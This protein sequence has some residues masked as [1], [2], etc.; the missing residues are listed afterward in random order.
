MVLRL[1]SFPPSP[2]DKKS[3]TKRHKIHKGVFCRPLHAENSAV[4]F[5]ES[6]LDD[7]AAAARALG[8]FG[9][10]IICGGAVVPSYFVENPI[11]RQLS[12]FVTSLTGRYCVLRAA[13]RSGP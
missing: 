12:I 4:G 13:N 5:N 10:E 8:G 9:K 1:P 2:A 6:L 7:A 11:E 3:A